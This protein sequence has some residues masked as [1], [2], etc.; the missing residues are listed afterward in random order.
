VKASE[1]YGE[2]Q[3]KL[4]PKLLFELPDPAHSEHMKELLEHNPRVKAAYDDPV[5]R[6]GLEQQL[7]L[8]FVFYFC[9]TGLHASHMIIGIGVM[10]WLTWRAHKGHF[11]AEYHTPIEISGL[12]WH[13][14]DIVWIFLFP[15]TY[16]LRH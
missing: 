2:Y 9:M 14:V 13:F 16:L 8:F 10:S 15:M 5:R 7:Q 4:I 11:S 1:Y 3:E 12:Y 6:K